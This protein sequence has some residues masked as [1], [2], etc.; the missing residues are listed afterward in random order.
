M[1]ITAPNPQLASLPRLVGRLPRAAQLASLSRVVGRLLRAAQLASLPRPVG[2]L[3]RAAPDALVRLLRR[4][5]AKCL[6]PLLLALPLA[7]QHLYIW[8]SSFIVSPGEHITVSFNQGNTLTESSEAI[9]MNLLRDYSLVAPHASYN[10]GGLHV[11]GDSIVGHVRIPR[12]GELLL[13]ARTNPAPLDPLHSQESAKAILFA[14]E[15]SD[16]Y[17]R[18]VGF[19]LEMVPDADPY[20]LQAGGSLPVLVLWRGKPAAGLSVEA[21]HST[22]PA[23][24]PLGIG[25]TGAD[26]RI[27]IPIATGKWWLR[28]QAG[29]TAGEDIFR[30][31]LTFEVR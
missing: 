4:F 7:A 11:K 28:A 15:A 30:T 1:R 5:S 8:P 12:K 20:A 6:L 13:T 9:N 23:A 17:R 3:P 19:A 26:G 25:K 10:I 18:V 21:A 31:S 2:R 22:G 29:G 24:T 14:K 16:L 27:A